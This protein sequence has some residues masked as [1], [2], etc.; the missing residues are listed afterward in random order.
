MDNKCSALVMKC[1][2]HL[3]PHLS[4]LRQGERDVQL[5]LE[6]V[7]QQPTATAHAKLTFKVFFKVE[8]ILFFISFG[9]MT[10]F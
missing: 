6:C 8:D 10:F 2:A 9:N 1:L 7:T 4:R 3:Y 5:V